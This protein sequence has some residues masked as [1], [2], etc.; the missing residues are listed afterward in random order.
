MVA[1]PATLVSLV[2]IL[3]H[4]TT[5]GYI[6]PIA[7]LDEAKSPTEVVAG[8]LLPVQCISLLVQY[9]LLV[10]RC[11][12]TH[13]LLSIHPDCNHIRLMCECRDCQES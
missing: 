6:H 4:R 1:V 11:C 2:M 8:L 9:R 3:I 13:S 7:K 12:G 5:M 10:S